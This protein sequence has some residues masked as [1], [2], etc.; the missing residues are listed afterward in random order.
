MVNILCESGDGGLYM[1]RGFIYNMDVED[2]GMIKASQNIIPFIGS[3][4]SR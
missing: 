1:F 4:I 2:C 3:P